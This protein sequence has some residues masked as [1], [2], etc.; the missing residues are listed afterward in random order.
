MQTEAYSLS[1][2]Y[3]PPN[4]TLLAVHA[5]YLRIVREAAMTHAELKAAH[6]SEEI[7]SVDFKQSRK[8]MFCALHADGGL[9]TL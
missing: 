4:L 6:H 8:H 1:L 9:L 3:S 7:N 5:T 2:L